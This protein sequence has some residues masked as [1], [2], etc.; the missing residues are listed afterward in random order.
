[1]ERQSTNEGGDGED[2]RQ[3]DENTVSPKSGTEKWHFVHSK[4]NIGGKEPHAGRRWE[5]SWTQGTVKL[6]VPG[7]QPG[8]DGGPGAPGKV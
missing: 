8:G 4:E 3:E 2:E 5:L 6:D 1:M 7:L